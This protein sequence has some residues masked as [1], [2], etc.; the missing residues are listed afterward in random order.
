[1]VEYATGLLEKITY[2]M[3]FKTRF[4]FATVTFL[5]FILRVLTLYNSENY[6]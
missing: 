3:P 6:G 5:S 1:M 4:L 2:H